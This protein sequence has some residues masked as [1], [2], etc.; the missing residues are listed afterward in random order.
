M[1]QREFE[2]SDPC[3]IGRDKYVRSGKGCWFKQR[4]HRTN[5]TLRHLFLRRKSR[6]SI[7]VLFLD[8]LIVIF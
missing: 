4:K 8:E 2:V 5:V 3:A 1:E 7:D 6:T